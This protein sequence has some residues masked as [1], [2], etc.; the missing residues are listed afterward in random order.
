[1][2]QR[3]DSAAPRRRDRDGGREGGRED[4]EKLAEKRRRRYK[5]LHR[6]S[7]CHRDHQLSGLSILSLSLSEIKGS[8]PAFYFIISRA[9]TIRTAG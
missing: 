4:E 2:R 5:R 6:H 8:L 7:V 1:M 3:G 9:V